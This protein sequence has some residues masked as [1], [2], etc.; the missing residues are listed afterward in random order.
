MA[1]KQ[2]AKNSA[3]KKS[4]QNEKTKASQKVRFGTLK[5]I[6]ATSIAGIL[7][8]ENSSAAY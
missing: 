3:K 8:P 1:K 2:K 7:M 6:A 4:R 5:A